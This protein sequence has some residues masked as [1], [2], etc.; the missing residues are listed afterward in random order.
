MTGLYGETRSESTKSLII[1]F[2]VVWQPDSWLVIQDSH[3][4]DAFIYSLLQITHFSAI[5]LALYISGRSLWLLQAVF[6]GVSYGW[7]LY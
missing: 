5:F 4:Q 1:L 2:N 3:I 6:T 7:E